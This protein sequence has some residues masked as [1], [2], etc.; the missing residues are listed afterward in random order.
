MCVD[1][2]FPA[3]RMVYYRDLGLPHELRRWNGHLVPNGGWHFTCM[4]GVRAVQEKIAAFA[5]QEYN[6][7]QYTDAARLQDQINRGEYAF[8]ESSGPATFRFVDVDDTLPA[9]VTANIERFADW[10]KL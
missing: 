1:R 9:C 4:G 5:H 7:S 10:I 8:Q 6:T 2:A 3:T